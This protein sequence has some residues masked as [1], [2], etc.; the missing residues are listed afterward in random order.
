MIKL[1]VL[2]LV[3]GLGASQY[4]PGILANILIFEKVIT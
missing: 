4:I 3:C 2:S 1:I